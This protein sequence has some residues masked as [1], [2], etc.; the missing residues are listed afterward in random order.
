MAVG[1]VFAI[2]EKEARGY[3]VPRGRPIMPNGAGVTAIMGLTNGRGS[4]RAWKR[5]RKARGQCRDDL[6]Q[7][8]SCYEPNRKRRTVRGKSGG[9]TCWKKPRSKYTRLGATKRSDYAYPECWA[10][11]IR[12][13]GPWS[14]RLTA[15][16]A[17]W[18]RVHGHKYSP[19]V[20]AR[21]AS[22]IS[23]SAR[24]LG[25]S[26]GGLNV[27][28]G[29]R[30]RRNA[31]GEESMIVMQGETEFEE[32]RRRRGR[33]R[34]KSKR[35]GRHSYGRGVTLMPRGRGIR[36]LRRN[37]FD[38]EETSSTTS[39]GEFMENARR[40]RGRKRGKARRRGK[41]R[42]RRSYGRRF[43][44]RAGRRY[45]RKSYA[46]RGK[47]RGRSKARRSSKGRGRTFKGIRRVGARRAGK[48]LTVMLRN[49]FSPNLTARDPIT[50]QYLSKIKGAKSEK[51]RA[52]IRAKWAPRL[53][54]AELQRRSAVS[55]YKGGYPRGGGYQALIAGMPWVGAAMQR[56]A[57]KRAEREARKQA[58]MAMAMPAVARGLRPR[59]LNWAMRDMT[60]K[61]VESVFPDFYSF[62]TWMGAMGRDSKFRRWAGKA[63]KRSYGRRRGYGRKR[64][65]ARGRYGRKGRRYGRKSR[66]YGRKSRRYG[67]GRGRGR[68]AARRR[69]RG[70]RRG[71]YGRKFRR[72][73]SPNMPFLSFKELALASLLALG[74]FGIIHY[75]SKFAGNLHP[76]AGA[77]VGLVLGGAA[78]F[79]ADK[80][81]STDAYAKGVAFAGILGLVLTAGKAILGMFKKPTAGFG[82][83]ADSRGRF[84]PAPANLGAFYQAQAGLGAPF[85][86][87]QA[88]L[89]APFYQAQAGFD[90]YYSTQGMGE[91]V[92]NDGALQPVSDMGEYVASHLAM[93]GYGDYE[94][95]SQ[96]TPGADGFGYVNEG[97]N[98]NTANLNHEFNL[99]EAAAGLGATRSDYIPTGMS[100]RVGGQESNPNAGVFDIGGSGGIFGQ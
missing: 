34:S 42:G 16:A 52:K 59:D 92:S 48:G 62:R 15:R 30:A 10:Y 45:G 85:Y 44:K 41:S 43:A 69:G 12:G 4:H 83:F 84:N 60:R 7:F 99:M 61:Q 74:S 64:F 90:D 72:N 38:P 67:R 2:T 49:Y 73:F 11:P 80:V 68:M 94:V 39:V 93:E 14:K 95:S 51:E 22:R 32:N 21:I 36:V 88:G 18:F 53:R 6:G 65:F 33:G 63:R 70:R 89:G 25:L 40:G 29:R 56:R 26:E 57:Q 77:G 97:V 78:A 5:S 71:R 47:G 24:S 91:Y 23:R 54:M 19:A 37:P 82:A 98:P 28:R 55:G 1:K 17:K 50:A 46:R 100:Q 31:Q 79:G 35:R 81:F 20:R 66:R 58:R 76:L 86:Q 27:G 96:Y 3:E 87:A 75:G 13:R 9:A 8:T